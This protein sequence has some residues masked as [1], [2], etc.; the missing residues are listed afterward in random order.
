MT[1]NLATFAALIDSRANSPM[2]LRVRDIMLPKGRTARGPIL[3][4][5]RPLVP[6]AKESDDED[7]EPPMR[8]SVSC[9]RQRAAKPVWTPRRRTSVNSIDLNDGRNGSWHLLPPCACHTT[10]AVQCVD[11]PLHEAQSVAIP[12]C[13]FHHIR[14][15]CALPLRI[16]V[17][18]M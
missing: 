18:G 4:G 11:A 15:V 17:V 16:C 7:Y 13:A 1:L 10:F 2:R 5:L 14:I 12:P 3:R 9:D 6:A 8:Q